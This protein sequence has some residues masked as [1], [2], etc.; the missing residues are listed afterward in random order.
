MTLEMLVIKI[1]ETE[2]GSRIDRCIRRILGNINQAM[3]EK[4][5]RSGLILLDNKKIKSSVKVN[6]G[7]LVKYSSFIKFEN[8]KIKQ[9]NQADIN[10]YYKNLYK[11]IFIKET[12][13]FIAINKPCGLAVQGGSS[14][15]Y[16]VDDMLKCIFYDQ[17]APKLVHRIDKDTSGLLLIAKNQKSAKKISSFFIEHK[18]IKTYL[19]IVSPCPKTNSG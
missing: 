18:I 5:L 16:H 15:K 7:Q 12:K 6:T 14:Q 19:A 2:D 3:L 11:R 1:P 4:Y 13:E 8:G 9:F 10:N 17:T